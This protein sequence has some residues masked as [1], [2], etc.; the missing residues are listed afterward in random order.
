LYPIRRLAARSKKFGKFFWFKL[1]DMS[2]LIN[3]ITPRKIKNKGLPDIE[4]SAR[5]FGWISRILNYMTATETSSRAKVPDSAAVA[6]GN[7]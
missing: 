5:P 7:L 4:L 3:N 6:L 1:S 2:H